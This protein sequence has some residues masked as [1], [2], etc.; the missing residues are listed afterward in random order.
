MIIGSFLLAVLLIWFKRLV[1]IAA[2]IWIGSLW[3][4]KW[5]FGACAGYVFSIIVEAAV[6][7]LKR[8]FQNDE[9]KR[10]G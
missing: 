1:F 5:Y 7:T 6:K 9:Q 2:G 8:Q 4:W 3:G 10:D